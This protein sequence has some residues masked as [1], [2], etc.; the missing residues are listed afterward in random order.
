MPTYHEI[1]T[2]DL[3]TLTA[4]AERWDGMA[5]EFAKQERAYRTG[6]YGVTAGPAAWAGMSAE[7]A[8]GRF[9]VTL[10]E[11][12]HARTEAKAI[13]SLLRDA[14]AQFVELKGRLTAVRREAA[15]VGLRVSDRGLVAADPGA[16]HDAGGGHE[17]DVHSWQ[18]RIDKAVRDITDADTGV[19]TAL[20]A[21]V[22]DS[23]PLAGGRGFNG[24]A[25]GDVEKYEAVEADRLLARLSRGA[26]LSDRELAELERAFR[27]NAADVEFSRT[28]LDGL[29]AD[30]TIRLTNQLN[31]LL[32]VRGGPSGASLRAC[33][34]IETGL[35]DSLATAARDTHSEWYRRWRAEMREAGVERAAT[36]A[37]G[38][39]LD[40]AV[41][42][43]S[44]VTLM[45]HGHGY[46]PGMLEDLTDD[47]IA[48]ERREPGIWRLKGTYAGRHDGW[49][50]ND[51]VDGALGLMSRDPGTAAHYLSDEARMTYLM[52][53]RDWDVTLHVREGPTA[54]RYV[55]GPDADDRAGLG[56][57]LQA[58]ATGI[59]P[60]DRRAHYV[61]HGAPNETVFRSA[62]HQ[63]A[64]RGD[65]FPP[66]LRRPMAA[67]LVN[68]GAT[69]HASMSEID[70]A[71]SP[72][73]QGE[74]FEVT[75]QV[76]KDEGAYGALN[77]GLNQAM[78]STI[79][80]DHGHSADSL[81]RAGRTVGFLEEARLQAQGDPKTAEFEAKPLFDKAI[82]YI[83]VASDDVQ[84]GFDYVTDQW[85]EDEQ[86]RLDEKQEEGNVR[87]YT[88]RNQQLMALA[89]EWSKAN[90]TDG[91]SLYDPQAEIHRSAG[92][93]MTH[94]LGVSGEP[95]K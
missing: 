76:S 70:I 23:D 53:D 6:V 42:Y 60:S 94:A 59:D 56:A 46:A 12:A 19:R 63:L 84:A 25:M 62:L 93:G 47:M 13:A 95:P 90:R 4:A 69:V 86:K 57:A 92:D 7:A 85:L 50:A 17:P 65:E 33:S 55:A 26:H 10:K 88:V 1:M 48:A 45:R 51:P 3:G 49:F 75:K 24:R 77:G 74:L 54:T 40:Q 20:T 64:D 37:Q 15:A 11:F 72:L 83:P 30:G 43:Q 89:R 39:R 22:V 41:G 35:A 34:A 31:D 8:H 14:H 91:D 61:S 21:V 27:D 73:D 81:T 18:A 44:L 36:A 9:A 79:H 82:S 38:A 32:Q 71:H 78:V 58:A 5:G 2:A 52:K 66:S 16:G 29:G 68:H 87:S 80:A 28:L 67:I